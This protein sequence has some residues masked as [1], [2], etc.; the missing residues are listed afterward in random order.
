VR[1]ILRVKARA[2]LFENPYVDAAEAERLA[3]NA[4]HQAVALDAA[5][6]SLVLLKNTG[7]LLP[8]DRGRI[9][10]LAVIGP[11]AKGVHLGGYSRD[12]GRGVDLLTGITAVAGSGVSVLYSE[13]TRITEDEPSWDR[14]AVTLGDPARNRKRIQEA[15]AVARKAD[16]IVLAIGT[17][18]STSREAYGDNHLGDAASLA[19]MGQQDELVDAMLATGKP[20]LVVL[21]NGRPQ[22]M[23]RVAERVPAILEAWY[24]GQEGGTAIAEAL[25]GVINPGGKLPISF[26]RETGQTPV[27]YNRRPTSFRG[28]VDLTREPLW[29]FGHGLS[30]TTF[31][32]ANPRVS[33]ATIGPADRATVSVDVTNTG[34]RAGDEVVQLYI[35]DVVSSVTRP[36]KELAG[37]ERVT[38]K[39]GE[40]RTVTLTIGPDAL[41]LVDRSMKRVV[42]P[43]TFELMV[44]TSSTAAVNG[45]LEVVA[46]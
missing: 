4:A 21:I 14:D 16:A 32:V 41:S 8:L 40:T 3:N 23:P 17:N 15:V 45:R 26:P 38:L 27:Y 20:V 37:F 34:S 29:P 28:Y 10:T 22:A 30:Y 44:G 5:R 24:A 6:R 35:R 7:N 2:G 25:F 46:K 19:L 39:P 43:G 11:N 31:T 18:E 36:V 13:G 9:K 1:R 33:P 12:P 42:E